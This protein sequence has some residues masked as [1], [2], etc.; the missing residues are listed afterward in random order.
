MVGAGRGT[1]I[2]PGLYKKMFT[3]NLLRGNLLTMQAQKT[4]VV[5]VK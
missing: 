1:R 2:V 3:S 4:A 5:M